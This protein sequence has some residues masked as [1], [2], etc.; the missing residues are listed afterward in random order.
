MIS[1]PSEIIFDLED[2]CTGCHKWA[3]EIIEMEN[4]QRKTEQGEF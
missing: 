1:N 2:K 4:R 3:Y